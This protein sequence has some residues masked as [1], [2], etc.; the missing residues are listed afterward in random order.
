M[1]HFV[2]NFRRT[3]NAMW[4]FEGAC[5]YDFPA[6]RSSSTKCRPYLA[7]LHFPAVGLGRMPTSSKAGAACVGL[8]H[9]VV[10]PEPRDGLVRLSTLEDTMKRA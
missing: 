4:R 5:L 6:T 3:P 8:T 1:L 9:S 2:V 7:D 10:W